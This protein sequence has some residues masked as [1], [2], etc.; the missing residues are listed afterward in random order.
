MR[1]LPTICLLAWAVA[2]ISVITRLSLEQLK[3]LVT[4]AQIARRQG[5][6][7]YGEF[8]GILAALFAGE[9]GARQVTTAYYRK[10]FADR[11]TILCPV[12]SVA[13]SESLTDEARPRLLHSEANTALQ[14]LAANAGIPAA[15]QPAR[16][17]VPNLAQ[18]PGQERFRRLRFSPDGRYLLAQDDAGIDL[19]GFDPFHIL[20]RIPA[21][22][23][24]RAEFTADSSQILFI[25]GGT[26][27]TAN[28][29]AFVHANPRVERWRIGDQARIESTEIPLAA[30][31]VLQ[32]SPEGR[33][34]G[35]IDFEG[36]LRL[37]AVSSGQTIFQKTVARPLTRRN[38][39]ENTGNATI[40]FSPD[41]RYVIF[42]PKNETAAPV[43]WDLDAKKEIAFKRDL[44]QIRWAAYVFAAPDRLLMTYT[45]YGLPG[46]GPV[47]E[48]VSFPSGRRIA[49]LP[50]LHGRLS[51]A[52]D[53]RFVLVRSG[54]HLPGDPSMISAV[55]YQTGRELIAAPLL[56]VLGERYV[57]EHPDGELGVHRTGGPPPRAPV[58]APSQDAP[59]DP[60]PDFLDGL[61]E[62]AVPPPDTRCS[63]RITRYS[64]DLHADSLW[65]QREAVT[66][67]G[68]PQD[69]GAFLND[70]IGLLDYGEIAYSHEARLGAMDAVSYSFRVAAEDSHWT[71]REGTHTVHA[72]YAGDIWFD[73]RTKQL[74][75]IA[76]RA[77][78]MPR[79]FLLEQIELS[80]D[81]D[82]EQLGG[83]TYLVVKHAM[84]SACR[85]QTTACTRN[86][87]DF[88][89]YRKG[90]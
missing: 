78:D 68:T 76:V 19:F 62:I 3:T 72:A 80:V 26:H 51:R 11:D 66:A 1:N 70:V 63:E 23:T 7:S 83:M 33:F 75:R 12:R 57:S 89:D 47:S 77:I 54:G 79:S 48:L 69:F 55:D 25:S 13:L 74:M 8:G 64:S 41:G 21:R 16:P 32:L 71:L 30:C 90:K 50:L 20:F 42:K 85:R 38:A 86:D 87:I 40:D 36:T 24:S 73:R 82:S 84:Q 60:H 2:P 46:S 4:S 81:Y 14:W 45:R 39:D 44:K 43:A 15:A 67:E 35:C 6:T 5:L 65:M 34:A 53:P 9:Q 88:T 59:S 28:Q 56:D 22:N 31:E 58:A 18:T 37:L 29:V 61:A 49:K 17:A 52:A 10:I 27:A